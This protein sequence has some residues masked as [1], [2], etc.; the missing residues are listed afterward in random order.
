MEELMLRFFE[1]KIVRIIFGPKR[2]EVPGDWKEQ[3]NVE[4]DEFTI[5]QILFG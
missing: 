4:L 3:Y 5:H 2:S 1:N